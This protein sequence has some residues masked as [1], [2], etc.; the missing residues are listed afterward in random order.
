MYYYFCNFLSR[1]VHIFKNV[2]CAKYKCFLMTFY[3]RLVSVP[4]TEVFLFG[5]GFLMRLFSLNFRY[6]WHHMSHRKD[7]SNRWIE[8][9]SIW[10]LKINFSCVRTAR[11]LFR[12]KI[13]LKENS[14]TMWGA[15]KLGVSLRMLDGALRET[16][17]AWLMHF[18]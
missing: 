10:A 17:N 12:N 13:R 11:F 15:S 6:Q 8:A 1:Y 14:L 2:H 4:F 9:I 3:H 16:L 5:L 7:L 18:P